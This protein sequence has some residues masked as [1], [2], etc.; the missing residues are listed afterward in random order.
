V[1]TDSVTGSARP[2]AGRVG[3]GEFTAAMAAVPTAVCVVTALDEHG[4]PHGMTVGSFCSLS[5]DPPLVLVCV[6]NAATCAP[7]FARCGSFAVS[8][9]RPGHEAVARRFASRGADKFG[10]D[11]LESTP[12]GLPVVRD[13]LVT[14]ECRARDRHPAGDHVILVGEV[15]HVAPREGP[16]MIYHRRRY[17]EVSS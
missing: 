6:S 1:T 9:L 4:R 2:A 13:A 12:S 10:A 14:V 17:T 15:V 8:V 16:A 3:A 5:L 7:A 11:D